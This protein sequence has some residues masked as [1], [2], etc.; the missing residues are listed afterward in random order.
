MPSQDRRYDVFLSHSNADEAVVADLAHR[1]ADAGLHPW[2]AASHLIP[3]EPW[4]E[5]MEAA[6]TQSET[7][8]VFIGPHGI[9]PWHNEQMRAA[10]DDAVQQGRRVIPVLLPGA[11]PEPLSPLLKRRTWVDFRAGLDNETAFQLLVAGIRGETP[12]EAADLFGIAWARR[13]DFFRH[14]PYPPNYVPRLELLAEMRQ[15]LLADAGALAL[16]SAIKMDALHGMGGIGKSVMARALCDDP[17]LQAVF[18]DGILWVTLG[19]TPDL[20]PCLRD[21][22]GALGGSITETAPTVER[23]K[24]ILGDLLRERACLLIV[25]DVWQR[26]DVETFR[27]GGPKCR[28]LFTTRHAS[29]A[30]DLAAAVHRVPLMT[31]PEAVVLLVEWSGN[32]LH[33]AAPTLKDTI[34]RRLGYLPLAIKLAGAQ[35]VEELPEQWLQSFEAVDLEAWE[36]E[37]DLD[38]LVRTFAKSLNALAAADRR[39]YVALAIFKEDEP[40]PVA[41]IARLWSTL[42]QRSEK[43][44]FRLLRDLAMRALLEYQ[45]PEDGS[46]L[47]AVVRIHDLL[48]DFMKAELGQSACVAAHRNLLDSY[49]QTQQ[50]DGWHTAPDDGYLYDHLAYHLVEADG[51]DELRRLLLDFDWLVAKLEASGVSSQ[52]ADFVSLLRKDK[53]PREDPELA[54]VRGALRLAA[55]ILVKDPTGA[56]LASQLYGRLLTFGSP[57]IVSLLGQIT[58]WRDKPWLHPLTASLVAPGGAL[59]STLTEH[60][61]TVLAVAVTADSRYAVSASRDG[62]LKV[63]SLE[64]G[65]ELR[66]LTGHT[67]QVVDV[68][69]TADGR[70]AVSQGITDELLWWDVQA[71]TQLSAPESIASWPVVTMLSQD[72]RHLFSPSADQWVVWDLDGQEVC[73]LPSLGTGFRGAVLTPDGTRVVVGSDSSVSVL[74]VARRGLLYSLHISGNWLWA[75]CLAVTPDSRRL[76]VASGDTVTMWDLEAG[77]HLHTFV[78]HTGRVNAVAVM[79]DGQGAISASEDFTLKVWDLDALGEVLSWNAHSD[80]VKAVIIT[81]DGKRA[82]SASSDRSLKVWDLENLHQGRSAPAITSV[83]VSTDSLRAISVAVDGSVVVWDVAGCK[84]LVALAGPHPKGTWLQTHVTE[85]GNRAVYVL[86]NQSIEVW[87]IA[88]GERLSVHRGEPDSIRE[89]VVAPDG[90]CCVS[91]AFDGA[92][93]VWELVP[94][95]KTLPLGSHPDRVLSVVVTLDNRRAIAG[96]LVAEPGEDAQSVAGEVGT[97]SVQAWDLPLRS[98]LYNLPGLAESVE[99]LEIAPDGRRAVFGIDPG[100]TVLWNIGAEIDGT[101]ELARLPGDAWDLFFARSSQ[102]WRAILKIVALEQHSLVIWNLENGAILRTAHDWPREQILATALD[103]ARAVSVTS[104][105]RRPLRYRRFGGRRGRPSTNDL[106]VWDLSTGQVLARFTADKLISDC[107]IT[108]DGRTIVAGDEAG[109]VHFLRLE[110]SK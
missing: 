85:D 47:S 86:N 81:P 88:S 16:T 83:K 87:D 45:R 37:T 104:S 73:R 103:G 5:A 92:L 41:A 29:I 9:G 84:P 90:Q 66:T 56:Q 101:H 43:R 76:L 68:A 4:Q 67:G 13:K 64:D 50:G 22:I 89:L 20:I 108:E 106:I 12:F 75:K 71:G 55:H 10:I 32:R 51:V 96:T 69:V 15:A 24:A 27:V 72:G 42:D 34:V 62:T 100:T 60:A 65:K 63:W 105:R 7:V 19:Q 57:G 14:I 39:L 38:S 91:I 70:R 36:V 59:M 49:R 23:L 40:I 25:D 82:I 33:Q 98:E 2:L 35:L 6:L 74:D 17:E 53:K 93:Q 95:G 1:L 79:P 54:L 52:I 80:N 97:A 78:G 94:D 99:W 26:T 28:L 58:R 46:D 102:G 18:A 8:A 110:E 109:Q 44:S 21:W 3:G 48:R 107:I 30:R 61:A 77:T 11:E 31:P